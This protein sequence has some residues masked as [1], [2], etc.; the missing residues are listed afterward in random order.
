M[1][2]LGAALFSL[3]F[4]IHS[5]GISGPYGRKGGIVAAVLLAAYAFVRGA[6]SLRKMDPWRLMDK[7]A[8]WIRRP[9]RVFLP[10]SRAAILTCLAAAA[11]FFLVGHERTDAH[12]TKYNLKNHGYD[13]VLA[14]ASKGPGLLLLSPEL[15]LFQLRTRRPV[16]LDPEYLD[17]LPYTPQVGPE[18]DRILTG[19]YGVNLFEPPEEIKQDPHGTLPKN[20]GR[21][22]WERR[23]EADWQ[24]L[25]K[26]FGVTQVITQPDWRLRLPV[27]AESESLKLY[28]IPAMAGN[29]AGAR[30]EGG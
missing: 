10:A 15:H 21:E 13:P 27:E 26:E 23:S 2:W 20:A 25:R 22:I 29:G 28:D 19:V 17:M 24:Q 16:L 3:P 6:E 9:A 12:F 30:R 4:L 14:A 1:L 18:L 11:V 5:L 7:F 8:S